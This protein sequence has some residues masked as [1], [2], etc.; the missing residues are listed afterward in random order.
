M[1]PADEL[2]R[3]MKNGEELVETATAAYI[4]DGKS[5]VTDAFHILLLQDKIYCYKI[6]VGLFTTKYFRVRPD[7]P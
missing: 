7:S 1:I 6:T 3:V 2:L 5:N 4:N